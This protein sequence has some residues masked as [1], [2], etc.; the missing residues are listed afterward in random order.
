MVRIFDTLEQAMIDLL[1]DV[2]DPNEFQEI[3][4]EYT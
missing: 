4:P 1:E 2:I 3:I